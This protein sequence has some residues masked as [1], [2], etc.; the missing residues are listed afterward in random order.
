MFFSAKKCAKLPVVKYNFPF[1]L[2]YPGL[3]FLLSFQNIADGIASPNPHAFFQP[4][5]NHVERRR[6]GLIILGLTEDKDH[7]TIN[8]PFLS[9]P[10][11]HRNRFV[12]QA[13]YNISLES[14]T[15]SPDERGKIHIENLKPRKYRLKIAQQ[16]FELNIALGET[17]LLLL[18]YSPSNGHLPSPAIGITELEILENRD[19]AI[20]QKKL[21]NL[22]SLLSDVQSRKLKPES[23]VASDYR[24]QQGKRKDF[25]A[26]LD[27][28]Q[29]Q[30]HNLIFTSARFYFRSDITEAKLKGKASW[31][32]KRQNEFKTILQINR[33]HKIIRH[34]TESTEPAKI[35]IDAEDAERIF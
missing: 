32:N 23:F 4:R 24:D 8:N 20:L 7:T 22:L 12:P 18:L 29:N 17:V 13:D 16:D 31:K 3:I 5:L 9:L 25:V 21:S 35:P 11:L 26:Y 2:I 33:N 34:Q 30:L 6:T 19:F 15:Y 1:F 27:Y 10:R 14:T 28:L